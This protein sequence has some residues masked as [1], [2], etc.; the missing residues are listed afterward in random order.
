MQPIIAAVN[1]KKVEAPSENGGQSSE[2]KEAKTI[3]I[4]GAA[5]FNRDKMNG[6]LSPQETRE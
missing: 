1:L 2:G 4:A 3:D 6:W 5:V